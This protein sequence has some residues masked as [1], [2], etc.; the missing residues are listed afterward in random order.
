MAFQDLIGQPTW[1]EAPFIQFKTMMRAD[2]KVGDQVTL[3]K[4]LVT[5]S[6]QAQSSLINQQVAFQGKFQIQTIRHVGN[7][8]QATGDAWVTVFDAFPL[9]VQAA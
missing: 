2:L 8:R 3:P 6:A 7:F 5:N 1:I 9:Q 4:T